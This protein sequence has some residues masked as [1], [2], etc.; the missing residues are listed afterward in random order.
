MLDTG[1]AKRANDLGS[2]LSA[3]DTC[4]NTEPLNRQ[5][6]TL[7]I[8]PERE[9]EVELTRVDIE[10]VERNT[11]TWRNLGLNFGDLGADGGGI[12]VTSSS[13]FNVITRAEDGRDKARLDSRWSHTSNHDWW[14]SEETRERSVNENLARTRKKCRLRC[15]QEQS[16]ECQETDLVF[17]SLGAHFLPHQSSY[18][19]FFTSYTSAEFFPFSPRTRTRTPR[20]SRFLPVSGPIPLRPP[21]PKSKA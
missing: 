4:S 21:G 9:L 11:N 14:L 2:L 15:D 6:L 13:E 7:E 16:M 3:R 20:P 10:G 18:L 17:T 12:V 8:L 1:L 5:A 19:T